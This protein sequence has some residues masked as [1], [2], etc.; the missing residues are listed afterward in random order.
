MM[1]DTVLMDVTS[2]YGVE[3]ELQRLLCVLGTVSL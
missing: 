3:E 2:S 1:F